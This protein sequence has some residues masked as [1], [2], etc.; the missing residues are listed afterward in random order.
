[1]KCSDALHRRHVNARVMSLRP[2]SR[3][4]RPHDR[5]QERRHSNRSIEAHHLLGVESECCRS[6]RLRASPSSTSQDASQTPQT[7]ATL[8]WPIERISAPINKKARCGTPHRA[9]KF[10]SSDPGIKQEPQPLHLEAAHHRPACPRR[11]PSGRLSY[12]IP[13][14][15]AAAWERSEDCAFRR[16]QSGL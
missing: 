12:G 4:E 11:Q 16:A 3:E 1:M 10:S 5:L 8:G 7:P 6:A 9:W 13:R 15:P 14:A 2:S